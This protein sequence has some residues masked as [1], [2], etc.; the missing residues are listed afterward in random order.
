MKRFLNA[1]GLG[2]PEVVLSG[3]LLAG[4]VMVSMHISKM[5]N[6]GIQKINRENSILNLHQEIIGEFMDP[7]ACQ[8]SLFSNGSP[9]P[10]SSFSG[11]SQKDLSSIKNKDGFEA[12]KV[13]AST[14]TI[15]DFIKVKRIYLSSYNS[16]TKM[17]QLKFDYS[18]LSLENKEQNKSK[19]I[20]VT[21]VPDST[22]TY[23]KYCMLKSV[24]ND[25]TDYTS[26]TV[27]IN[28]APTQLDPTS[29]TPIIFDVIFSEVIDISSFTTNDITQSGT[30][31]V[32]SWTITNSGDNKKFTLQANGVSVSGTVI[33]ILNAA[34]VQDLAGNDNIASTGTNKSVTFL[35]PA[36]LEWISPANNYNFGNL[37]TDSTSISFTLK[38]TGGMSTTSF[39][40]IS[41][42]SFGPFNITSNGCTSVVLGPNGQCV[43]S[44]NF[45]AGSSGMNPGNYSGGLT[46]TSNSAGT[47]VINFSGTIASGSLAWNT[48][49]PNPA[50]PHDYGSHYALSSIYTYILRNS[51]LGYT[52]T[53]STSQSG[54]TARWEKLTDN[55]HG[56]RLA[57]A[58]TCSIQMRFKG[59]YANGVG[60]FNSSLIA[61]STNGGTVTYNLSGTV[62]YP[63]AN[64]AFVT[65]PPNPD[66]YGSTTTNVTRQYTVKNNSDGPSSTISITNSQSYANA[67]SLGTEPTACA[68]KTLIAQA[69]C[70][71]TLTFNAASLP[72]TNYTAS[73]TFSATNGGSR[74]VNVSGTVSSPPPPP[75]LLAWSF[76]NNSTYSFGTTKVNTTKNFTLRNTGS[77]YTQS[78]SIYFDTYDPS[79]WTLSHS[80]PTLN[81]GASCVVT[82]TFLG[83]DGPAAGLQRATLVARGDDN[84]V[85]ISLDG[86]IPPRGA[87]SWDGWVENPVPFGSVGFNKTL[88]HKLKNN[89]AGSAEG[90]TITKAGTNPSAWNI[91]ED[92]PTSLS[93]GAICNV[94]ATFLGNT[95]SAG[96]YSATINVTTTNKSG[97][98]SLNLAGTCTPTYWAPLDSLVDSSNGYD[99]T[100]APT[101]GARCTNTPGNYKHL[102][103]VA[104]GG[105]QHLHFIQ[106][107]MWTLCDTGNGYHDYTSDH[108]SSTQIRDCDTPTKVWS[109][110]RKVYSINNACHKTS[111]SSFW[112]GLDVKGIGTCDKM[113]THIV[114]L[115]KCQ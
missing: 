104:L 99:F 38:N 59:D 95:L 88:S 108:T 32:T 12:F 87:I 84:T 111:V 25:F 24:A 60:S 65:V 18:F 53:I 62:T 9:V 45:Q 52:G 82:V 31:T 16:S 49:S 61:A 112:S 113:R 23:A 11:T 20:N 106:T 27:T 48:T 76:Y 6:K 77:G 55:C 110:R 7:K 56:I 75:S 10:L 79:Y 8:N 2:L 28:R 37:G 101:S 94:S 51:G 41:T 66:S 57:P 67:W 78:L 85:T 115:W 70:T 15:K 34:K 47:P 71:I 13:G 17:A 80:C 35:L 89:G 105:T 68:G 43:V 72:A 97:N 46:T 50:N 39:S 14:G 114:K 91:S 54:T 1:R 69:T 102:I 86:T 98:I 63:P 100:T 3:A 4:L 73:Y 42:G 21:I 109:V 64:L 40:A 58:G 107:P 29:I 5:S 81:A 83:A 92:C 74:T 33:P 90:V 22:N 93:P 19:T 30:A 44:V 96:T 36:Q 103:A 26:P